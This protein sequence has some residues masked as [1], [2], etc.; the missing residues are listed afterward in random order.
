MIDLHATEIEKARVARVDEAASRIVELVGQVQVEAV[1]RAQA[2]ETIDPVAMAQEVGREIVKVLT[3]YAA[4]EV[5]HDKLRRG[6][7]EGGNWR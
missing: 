6:G 7:R 4:V 3:A 2:G 5:E 1:K